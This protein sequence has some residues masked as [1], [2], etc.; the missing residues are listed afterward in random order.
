MRREL[1]KLP[2]L[3]ESKYEKRCAES[4]YEKCDPFRPVETHSGRENLPP[5]GLHAKGSV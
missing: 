4:K 2:V 5:Q 3:R 1:R